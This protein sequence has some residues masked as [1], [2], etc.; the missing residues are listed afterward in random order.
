MKKAYLASLIALSLFSSGVAAKTLVTVNGQKIDSQTIDARV[1]QLTAQSQGQIQDSPAVR[2]DLLRL[3]VIQT[4]VAEEAKRLKLNEQ[5]DF[6]NAIKQAREAAKKAGDD[7]K[8]NFK[9][10]WAD[11][12][13][14]LLY[15]AYIIHITE[16]NPLTEQDLRQAYNDFS[17]FYQGSEEIQLGE[18]VTA[19]EAKAQAAYAALKAKK[20]FKTVAT[21]YTENTKGKANGG[22]VSTEYVR[23]KDLQ[24]NTPEHIYQAINGLKKG[25]YTQPQKMADGVYMIFYANDKRKVKLPSFEQ[26]KAG[27]AMQMQELRIDNAIEGLLEKANIKQH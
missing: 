2:N 21:E 15:Q 22:F 12:E 6:K 20:S 27:L 25:G 5:A 23:L 1:K 18:I 7:K 4:V 10:Q 13:N 14:T 3:Q 26:A 9:Q 8:P 19:T 17:K 24:L 16:K 11:Y